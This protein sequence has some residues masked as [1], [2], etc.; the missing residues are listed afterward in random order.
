MTCAPG[1]VRGLFKILWKEGRLRG[2]GTDKEE[3]GGPKSRDF[4]RRHLC[5]PPN[6]SIWPAFVWYLRDPIYCN[7][8]HH[9]HNLKAMGWIILKQH[10]KVY[11]IFLGCFT[12]SSII[13]IVVM[14]SSSFVSIPK[15]FI[16][17]SWK[18]LISKSFPSSISCFSLSC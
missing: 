9:T 6:M 13:L 15:H 16:T 1:G 4:R 14:Q 11:I 10:V 3:G 7:N 18:T 2:F 12:P 8:T 17:L 5:M